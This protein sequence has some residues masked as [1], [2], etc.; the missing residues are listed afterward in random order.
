MEIPK[1]FLDSIRAKRFD[2]LTSDPSWSKYKDAVFPW[3]CAHT[4]ETTVK[5]FLAQGSNPAYKK[6]NPLYAA[7]SY[8][9][10]DIVKI[11][12]TYE[13]VRENAAGRT[14]RSLISAE[15]EGH[16][17]IVSA[18]MEIPSVAAGPSMSNLF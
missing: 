18:L 16:K 3:V 14:N 7:C 8:N 11:L 17:E 10:L 4:D 9:R 1:T 12:L 13:S 5:F 15:Q 2:A 6:D